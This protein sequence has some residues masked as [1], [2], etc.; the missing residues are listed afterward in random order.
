[1]RYIKAFF[2]GIIAALGALVLEFIVSEFFLAIPLSKT[3]STTELFFSSISFLA[4]AAIIEESLKYIV[5]RK[6]I[7][8]LFSQRSLIFASIFFG[9]GFFATEGFLIY[10]QIG[11]DLKIHYTEILEVA[12]LHI[13]TAGIAGYLIATKNQKQI[14]T[15]ATTLILLFAVHFVFNML[16]LYRDVLINY[17]VLSYLILLI[18]IN[19]LNIRKLSKKLAL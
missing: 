16:V 17:V 18:S 13:S 6:R 19:I 5:I 15:V 9:L 3:N 1:M 11:M 14:K 2:W 10:G 12:L 4:I 8:V 7:S